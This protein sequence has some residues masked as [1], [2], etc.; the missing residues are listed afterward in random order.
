MAL[1]KRS[2]L[3]ARI[4]SPKPGSSFVAI[5][6]IASGVTS[7]SAMPFPPVS[8]T[9]GLGLEEALHLQHDLAEISPVEH[10]LLRGGGFFERE[11]AVNN[12]T[13]L[14]GFNEAQDFEQFTASA[15]EAAD[16][17]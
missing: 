9:F 4:T 7:R 17:R 6:R 12:G 13:E 10:V 3:F 8:G 11:D 5:A 15:H 1:E 14:A 16:D 2:K